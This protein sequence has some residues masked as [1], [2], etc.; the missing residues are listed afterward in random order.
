[1]ASEQKRAAE[2]IGQLAAVSDPRGPAAEAY[3]TLRTN[4]R[5]SSPDQRLQSILITSPGEN[6]G[7]TTTL[8]NLGVVAAQAG[9]RVALVDCDLRRPALHEIFELPNT[10][11]LSSLFL[12]GETEAPPLLPTA[13]SGLCILT[14]GPQPPNP[15]DLLASERFAG[16]LATL[17]ESYDLVLLDCAPVTVA[18]DASILAPR[19]DGVLLV[20]DARRTKRDQAQRA[21]A[22]LERVQARILGVSLNNAPVETKRYG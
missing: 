20:L 2:G 6:E 8:A 4:L 17:R 14:S 3:R 18:A 7:K 16:L 15:A 22:Q 13:V 21:K 1:M 12:D 10:A 9:T 11:G 5:F 19:V